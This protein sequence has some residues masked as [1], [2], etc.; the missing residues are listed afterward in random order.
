[1]F[2]DAN[3]FIQLGSYTGLYPDAYDALRAWVKYEFC[4][5][6]EE[7][8]QAILKT[9]T[10]LSRIYDRSGEY[11]KTP[12][13]DMSDIDFVYETMLKYNEI[14]PENITSARNFRLFYL[15]A[16]IDYEL[17]NNDCVP[18]RSE[19]CQTHIKELV[20]MYYSDERTNY[21]VRPPYNM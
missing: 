15:R 11:V 21:W 13:K 14:L 5:D 18:I 17:K 3:K 19:R 16:I 2:E 8:Y 12:I 7:L 10:S 4:C 20:D 1:V 6:D 9:E